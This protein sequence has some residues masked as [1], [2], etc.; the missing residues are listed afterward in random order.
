MN[1]QDAE[2]LGLRAQDLVEVRSSRGALQAQLKL[3]R[4]FP[5]GVVFVPENYRILRLNSLM[6]AGEYPCPVQVRKDE[7]PS[8]PLRPPRIRRPQPE[9]APPLGMSFD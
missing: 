5:R 7:R 8:R 4:H 3:S 9:P 6:K 1:P 2:A